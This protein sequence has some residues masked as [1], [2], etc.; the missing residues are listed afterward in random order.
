MLLTVYVI[1]NFRKNFKD[2]ELPV[3]SYILLLTHLLNEDKKS[4][5]IM[6]SEDFNV[7]SGCLQGGILS[8]TLFNK[9]TSDMP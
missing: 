8:P 3:N 9:Y 4:N 5:I 7:V 6:S 1:I 2:P